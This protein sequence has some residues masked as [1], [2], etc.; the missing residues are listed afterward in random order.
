MPTPRLL[1]ALALTAGAFV[2]SATPAHAGPPWISIELP[3]NPLD[4]TTRGA[5]LLVHTFHHETSLRQLLEGRA[6]GLVN[7]KRQ[8]ITLTFTDTSRDFVRALRRTWP[9]EGVWV[10]V[11]TTGG[12]D[13]GATAVVGIGAD[14]Q[15]RSIDV[16]TKM[17][18]NWPIPQPVTQ[19]D[20]NALLSK[21]AAAETGNRAPQGLALALGGLLVLPA[22]LALFRRVG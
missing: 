6:E 20:I 1:T 10:L 8:T 17:Q 11:L 16:P 12:A 2:A 7:G 3:A 13:H 15:V 21:M 5:Y 22:G 9:S 18:D 14:G 4:R 19:A